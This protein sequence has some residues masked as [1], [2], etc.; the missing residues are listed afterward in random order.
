[1][2]DGGHLIN[3]QYSF[4][5]VPIWNKSPSSELINISSCFDDFENDDLQAFWDFEINTNDTAIDRTNNNNH[6]FLQKTKLIL[7]TLLIILTILYSDECSDISISVLQLINR[8]SF[9]NISK[10]DSYDWNKINLY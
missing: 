3:S 5:N 2:S 1:M 10:R 8:T 6:A 9:V 4:D 7:K